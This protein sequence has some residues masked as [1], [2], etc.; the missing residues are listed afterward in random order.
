M[1]YIEYMGQ[2]GTGK[3]KSE[4]SLE[5]YNNKPGETLVDQTGRL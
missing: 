1:S 4:K 3:A 5:D 2:G